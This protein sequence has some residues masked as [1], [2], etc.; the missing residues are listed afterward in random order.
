MDPN[1]ANPVLRL[2]K[3]SK[4]LVMLGTAI[5]AFVLVG[6]G[7]ISWDQVEKFLVVTVP[8]WMLAVGI[9]DGAKHMAG[10]TDAMRKAVAD[11]VKK[12]LPPPPA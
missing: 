2:L 6:L 11:E 1:N 10:K 5:G 4:A 9:E 7:K 12:S 3:S 8:A